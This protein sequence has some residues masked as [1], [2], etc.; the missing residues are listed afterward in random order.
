[1]PRATTFQVILTHEHTDFDALASLLAAS[2]LYPDALPVLPRQL[3]RNVASF[4]AF[5]HN[6][7]P[8]VTD[9]EL[10]RG[11]V[12]RAIFVD[13]R[14]ANWVKGMDASA[15]FVIID[16][17]SAGSEEAERGDVLTA[18]ESAAYVRSL[19]HDERA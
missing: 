11:R 17:H 6:Q 10:P 16:H 9:K 5:Y 8:F 13:T 18:E 19:L 14:S 4:L 2:L 15:E 1:M 7:L 3:N 12:T